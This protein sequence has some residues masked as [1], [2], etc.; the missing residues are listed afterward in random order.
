MVASLGTPFSIGPETPASLRI[1]HGPHRNGAVIEKSTIT[2]TK[3]I[4]RIASDEMGGGFWTALIAD[5]RAACTSPLG[6][7]SLSRVL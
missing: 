2:T 4:T 3:T 1:N 6:A 7:I 5:S